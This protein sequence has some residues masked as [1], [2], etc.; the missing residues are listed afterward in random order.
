MTEIIIDNLDKNT[1]KIN[2]I[3]RQLIPITEDCTMGSRHA[4]MLLSGGKPITSGI[5][6]ARTC[7]ANQMTLSFHAEMDVLS[8][9]FNL[10][11][12]YGLRNFMNDSYF[13][14]MGRKNESYLLLKA[15]IDGEM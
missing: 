13:T 4:A 9:Y 5:N 2:R 10:N 8:K 12:E 1:E 3:L 7:N 6:H 15:E 14:M 11:H